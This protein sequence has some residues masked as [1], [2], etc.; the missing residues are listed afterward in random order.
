MTE[1]VLNLLTLL[2]D[3]RMGSD[4]LKI[5]IASELLSETGMI[6]NTP[7]ARY[8]WIEGRDP[9]DMTCR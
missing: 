8:A 1:S 3:A 6:P 7:N 5:R 2:R 4:A 9:G